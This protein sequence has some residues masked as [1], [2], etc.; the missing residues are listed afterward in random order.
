MGSLY[1]NCFAKMNTESRVRSLARTAFLFVGILAVSKL[2]SR[3]NQEAAHADHMMFYRAAQA[4]VSGGDPYD[5]GYLYMPL[6]AF[7]LTPLSFLPGALFGLIW[8]LLLGLMW[9]VSRK[10]IR[11]LLSDP[12]VKLHWAV[13]ILPSVLLFRCIYNGWGL[14]Q[15]SLYLVVLVLFSLVLLRKGNELACGLMLGLAVALKVFPIFMCAALLARSRWLALV[16]VFCFALFFTVSPAILVG[17]ERLLALIGHGFFETAGAT[18]QFKQ[19]DPAHAGI[20]PLVWI[21][22]FEGAEWALQ[23]ANLFWGCACVA[24]VLWCRPVASCAHQE[25]LWL[26]FVMTSMLVSMPYLSK[27]YLTFLLMP[28]AISIQYLLDPFGTVCVKRLLAVGL[29][30]ATFAFNFYSPLLVGKEVSQGLE[31]SVGPTAIGLLAYWLVY[32]LAV[33][34]DRGRSSN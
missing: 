6:L 34:L 10:L 15:I 11:I 12:G 1:L 26:G 13:D 31:H 33:R 2:T 16:W 9:I 32:G 25:N 28:Y 22:V 20:V 27:N 23:V 7:L 17:S 3:G 8:G 29:S 4:M 5:S 30:G 19:L 21:H 24:M 14:G 18:I